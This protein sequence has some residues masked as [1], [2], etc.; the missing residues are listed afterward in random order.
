MRARLKLAIAVQERPALLIL[1]EPGAGLDRQGS[2]VLATVIEHQREHGA[3]LLATND[4]EEMN[5]ATHE[6]DFS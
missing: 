1:D 5:L 6:F 3:V 4:P 2:A